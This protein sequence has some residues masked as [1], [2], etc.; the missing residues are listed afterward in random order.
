V[1][2]I[3]TATAG[4]NKTS[5]N[6]AGRVEIRFFSPTKETHTI[7]KRGRDE[8]RRR[9]ARRRRRQKYVL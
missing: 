8:N 4:E 9:K 7:P 1:R 2:L 3:E 6:T 5:S